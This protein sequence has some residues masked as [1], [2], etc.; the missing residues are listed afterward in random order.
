MKKAV[1]VLATLLF[2]A[3]ASTPPPVIVDAKEVKTVVLVPCLE[4]KDIPKAPE[5][6]LDKVDLVDPKQEL[7][8]LVNA[9]T[10]ELDIR[11]KWVAEVFKIFNNCA[12]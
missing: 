11:R 6:P 4:R 3:C 5:F 2:T 9:A 10:L 8:R 12:K 1:A 7:A